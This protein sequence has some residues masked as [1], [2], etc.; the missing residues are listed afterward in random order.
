MTAARQRVAV[1]STHHRH[2]AESEL[3]GVAAGLAPWYTVGMEGSPQR[4]PIV[5]LAALHGTG[6]TVV[7]PRVAERLGVP[8]LGPDLPELVA[9][10]AGL[11]RQVVA[12]VDDEPRSAGR[13]ANIFGRLST[14]TAGTGGSFERLDLEQRTLRAYIEEFLAGCRATGGVVLGRGGMV[15]LQQVPWALHVYLHG[16]REARVRQGAD[17]A[18]TDEAT[19]ARRQKVEDK[20]RRGYVRSVYGVDGDDPSLY[21][22][23]LDS[24]AL[25]LEVCADLIVAAATER[26]RHPGHAP[27]A[28]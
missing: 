16:P 15:V 28:S 5:T 18:G 3:F 2:C 9:A 14:L 23:A 22:V 6:G 25:N 26:V 19:A 27:A 10:R 12:E 21:H 20:A 8:F 4:P 1:D 7:G 24:T 17:I 11:P 13:L